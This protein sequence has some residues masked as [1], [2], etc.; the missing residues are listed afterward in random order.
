MSIKVIGFLIHAVNDLFRFGERVRITASPQHSGGTAARL[1][2]PHIA[3]FVHPIICFIQGLVKQG[4]AIFSPGRECLGEDSNIVIPYGMAAAFRRGRGVARMHHTGKWET[5]PVS[6]PIVAK[7]LPKRVPPRLQRMAEEEAKSAAQCSVPEGQKEAGRAGGTM[8][9]PAAA[10]EEGAQKTAVPNNAAQAATPMDAAGQDGMKDA[11]EDMVAVEE[12]M[13]AAAQNAGEDARDTAADAGETPPVSSAELGSIVE[14]DGTPLPEEPAVPAVSIGGNAVFPRGE[15]P[16][17]TGSGTW[18]EGTSS[19]TRAPET[20][21]QTDQLP[22]DGTLS[23]LSAHQP[24][25]GA[26]APQTEEETAAWGMAREQGMTEPPMRQEETQE[27]PVRAAAPED[28]EGWLIVQT[29]TASGALPVPDS[30]VRIA[31]RTAQGE[32]LVAFDTTTQEGK[33]RKIALSAPNRALSEHPT[34]V[35]PFAVYD[36]SIQHAYF[37]S[38]EIRDVQVFGDETSL[39]QVDLIPLPEF[40]QS[41]T[42]VFD[43]PPQNL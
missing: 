41:G 5:E 3:Y 18:A 35:Q 25:P 12:A 4:C 6:A 27:S 30:T 15:R 13:E 40:A 29:F 36:V 19:E 33:T 11:M 37:Y 17:I 38:V 21:T 31:R 7:K 24:L 20:E 10:P 23:N 43:I 32:E 26:D 42:E 1:Q 39:Q 34:D 2:Q 16:I 8:P 14:E 22:L 28:S 9:E